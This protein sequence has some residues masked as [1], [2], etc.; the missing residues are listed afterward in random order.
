MFLRSGGRG[1]L[2]SGTPVS[3]VAAGAEFGMN[4]SRPVTQRSRKGNEYTRKIGPVFLAPRRQGYVVF[5]SGKASIS[6]VA[7]LWIQT[8]ARTLYDAAEG[9]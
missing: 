8:A 3:V 6:R 2:S 1:T 4:P 9:S 5:E 7:S